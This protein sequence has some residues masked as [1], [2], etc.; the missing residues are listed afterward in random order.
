MWT[1]IPWEGKLAVL[2]AYHYLQM[3]NWGQGPLFKLTSIKEPLY[4]RH[5]YIYYCN[6]FWKSVFSFIITWQ[7]LGL[8]LTF[9][10]LCSRFFLYGIPLGRNSDFSMHKF[11]FLFSAEV[12]RLTADK[13][14]HT[15]NLVLAYSNVS[16]TQLRKV[17]SGHVLGD[18]GISWNVHVREWICDYV[19]MCESVCS[20]VNVQVCVCVCVC[21]DMCI[22]VY[23]CISVLC[24]CKCVWV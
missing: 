9:C 7:L 2:K 15:V 13:L 10:F 11:A 20:C 24:V 3:L 16:Q 18:M 19:W 22:K 8:I 17:P 23:I 6:Y 12:V 1:L 4:G 21:V 5:F 14:L